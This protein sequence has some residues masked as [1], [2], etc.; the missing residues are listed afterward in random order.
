MAGQETMSENRSHKFLTSKQE[1][2]DY[3][4]ISEVLFKKFIKAGMPALYIDGR[5]Y[6]HTDNLDDYFKNL[7]RVSAKNVPEEELNKALDT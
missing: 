4:K 7:T 3:C 6:A 1:I 5:W 2:M